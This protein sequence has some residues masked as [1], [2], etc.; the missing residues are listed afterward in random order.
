MQFGWTTDEAASRQVMDAF[1]EAGGNFVDTADIYT[2]WAGDASYGGKTEEIIGRWL[3]DKGVRRDL[4]L[5]TKVRGR[6]WEGPNGEGL[7]RQ[8]IIAA[9][10]GL[11]AA[12][13]RPTTLTST[14]ATGPT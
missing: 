10:E 11:A 6:M 3:R 13:S 2:T 12:A 8:H 5:A 1:W 4:V 7:S 9:C 14:S